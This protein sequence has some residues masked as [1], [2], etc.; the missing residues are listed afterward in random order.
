MAV[1]S[2][3]A[4]GRARPRAEHRGRTARSSTTA[5]P[6]RARTVRWARSRCRPRGTRGW[7]ST[8]RARPEGRDRDVR[9]VVVLLE[10]APLQHLRAL[11][12]FGGHVVGAVREVPEDGVRL[13]E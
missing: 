11:V 13:P 1:D 3:S 5:A 9:L 4:T 8:P 12:P 7:R 6:A 10:A 2:P